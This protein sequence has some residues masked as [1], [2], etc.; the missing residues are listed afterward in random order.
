[1]SENTI[2]SKSSAEYRLEARERLAGNW[3][4][5]A[6]LYLIIG[7]A[8]LAIGLIPFIGTLAEIALSGPLALGVTLC[9]IK[10]FKDGPVILEDVLEG[11]RNF[12]PALLVYLLI[13]LFTLLWG[14]LFIIPGIVAGYS[15]SMAY[16]ILL[17]S[18]DMPPTEV[19]RRS[20]AMM[21]G[22][23]MD[24]F[25]LHL[26]FVGWALLTILTLGIGSL[27]LTPYVTAATTA[28]YLDLKTTQEQSGEQPF[29][30]Y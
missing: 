2:I 18:P 19:L 1:M 11:F 20:K 5:F 4:K 27:W 6:L 10:L 30:E 25:I 26:T 3:G 12:V 17:E 23:R 16:Y 14:L 29:S 15:Y 8:T 9:M 7:V 13:A 24:L 21:K 22:H 28:F